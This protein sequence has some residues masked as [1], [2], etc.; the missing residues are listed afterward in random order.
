MIRVDSSLC[1][2]CRSCFNVCPSQN[3]IRSEANGRATVYWKSCKEESDLCVKMC[4]SKALSL[5]S[6]DE[7]EPPCELSFDLAACNICGSLYA[8]ELMLE[9]IESVLPEKIQ[10]DA[11]GLE[12]IRICPECRRNKEAESLTRLVLPGRRKEDWRCSWLFT[13]G[14]RGLHP[15]RMKLL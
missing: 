4:P 14:K 15:E 10:K 5:V 8:T 11:A 1:L 13:A 2:G 3:I 9:W 12:W 6:G 7:A